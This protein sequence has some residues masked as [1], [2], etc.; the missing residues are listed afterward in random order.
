MRLVYVGPFDRVRVPLAGGR[1]VEA[2]RFEEIDVPRD[3]AEGLLAQPA[4]FRRPPRV[5]KNADSGEKKED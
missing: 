5:E 4:N 3:V 2:S 1:E